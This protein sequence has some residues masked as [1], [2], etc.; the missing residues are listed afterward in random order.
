MEAKNETTWLAARGFVAW[1]MGTASD[2]STKRMRW[3]YSPYAT[4]V[5]WLVRPS[6]AALEPVPTLGHIR[7]RFRNWTVLRQESAMA[8]ACALGCPPSAKSSPV[9]GWIRWS[10]ISGS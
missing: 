9:T 8:K 6:A 3:A 1:G 10:G 7:C 5:A 2:F 4:N